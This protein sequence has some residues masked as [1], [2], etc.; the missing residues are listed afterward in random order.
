MILDCHVH[1]LPGWVHRAFL[2][3]LAES[4]STEEGPAALWSSPAFTDRTSQ[5]DDLDRYGI[6]TAL[7]THS[8]NAITAMHSAALRGPRPRTGPAAI[9][10]VNDELRGWAATTGGRLLATRW[11]DPRLADSAL[12]EIEHARTDGGVPAVSMHTAYVD[13]TDHRLRFLD[14]P[15]FAPVLA[16]AETA[17][18]TVFVHASAKFGLGSQPPLP[19]LAGNCL[20]GGLSM[21]VENTLCVARMVLSGTFD[22]Y[23]RLRLVFG[24]L[25]GVLPIVL[26]R[27]DLIH[28]LLAGAD[29]SARAVG[30]LRRLR[31]Y[32]DHVY[33]DTHSMDAPALECAFDALGAD[34]IVFGSDFPVTPGRLGRAGGLD[35]LRLAALPVD[36]LHAIES[37]TARTLLQLDQQKKLDRQEEAA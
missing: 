23:P 36:E 18:V 20:T 13:R 12:T 37:G 16:A 3:W 15:E 34:R 8:S 1:A 14:D 35:A 2:D 10:L 7:L 4:G 32:T 17:G 21:L 33:A 25:G 6:D 29:E 27:F 24:Q 31:D 11:V 28:G 30:A 19:D 22:R 5:L 26:G 9:S